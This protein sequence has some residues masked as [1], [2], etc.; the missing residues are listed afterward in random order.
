MDVTAVIRGRAGLSPAW[1]G[2]QSP[3]AA[4]EERLPPP[5]GNGPPGV[6]G[7]SGGRFLSQLK[8]QT[9]PGGS[10]S[11]G[12]LLHKVSGLKTQKVHEDLKKNNKCSEG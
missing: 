9:L 1:R 7:E 12:E 10:T 2:V 4:P 3:T 11:A 5:S 8:E 6:I